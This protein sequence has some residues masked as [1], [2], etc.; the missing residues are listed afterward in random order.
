MRGFFHRIP[1]LALCLSVVFSHA[2]AASPVDIEPAPIWS[3][4]QGRLI[5]AETLHAHVERADY[6]V[7]GELHDNAVHHRWQAALLTH[8]ATRNEQATVGFEQ[9]HI[10]QEASLD[11]YLQTADKN[12][13]GLRSALDWDSSGWPDF[14]LYAPIFTGVLEHEL[15]VQPLMLS[16]DM[17][18]RVLAEGY[19]SIL[20]AP[21]LTVLAPETLLRGAARRQVEELMRTA[22][23]GMLPEDR[24]PDMVRVQLARD[25]FMAWRAFQA[26]RPGVLI[27]GNGHARRDR[28]LPAFLQRLDPDA[29]IVVI[30]LLEADSRTPTEHFLAEGSALV[31]DY[32]ILTKPQER[33]DP[34]EDFM[35]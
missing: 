18:R 15:R 32:L 2:F 7:L 26:G 20:P 31:S 16:P 23:C 21:A 29:D 3:T 19:E 25:A 28:G 34:C 14:Q 27:T 5:S 30:S 10:A 9:I 35:E 22:H 8:F 4:A 1:A 12:L 17:T 13:E 24:I 11:N 33:D 6:L